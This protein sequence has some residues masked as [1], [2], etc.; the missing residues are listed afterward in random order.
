MVTLLDPEECPG[1][2]PIGAACQLMEREWSLH[3][4]L[5][6]QIMFGKQWQRKQF[7]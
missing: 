2:T 3:P 6:A 7:C 4:M 1:V 5:G